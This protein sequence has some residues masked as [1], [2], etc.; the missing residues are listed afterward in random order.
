MIDDGFRLH[1]T[2]EGKGHAAVLSHISISCKG[3]V[4]THSYTELGLIKEDIQKSAKL[5]HVR[6]V[7]PNIP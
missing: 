4:L 2:Q 6:L 5:S 7:W 3:S 1:W